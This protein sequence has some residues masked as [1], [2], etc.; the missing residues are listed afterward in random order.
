MTV[1]EIS[2]G[3]LKLK[4]SM[5]GGAVLLAA[6][7]AAAGCSTDSAPGGAPTATP[8]PTLSVLER[9]WTPADTLPEGFESLPVAEGVTDP[10]QA[11]L[12]AEAGPIRYFLAPATGG[13]LC[14][15][16]AS[17]VGGQLLSAGACTDKDRITSTGLILGEGPTPEEMTAVVVV[18]DGVTAVRTD[19][20]QSFPAENNLAFLDSAFPERVHLV[21]GAFDGTVVGADR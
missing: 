9:A 14:L 8:E 20:G 13:Q 7:F 18:P 3:T 21:G 15:V 10:A 2:G 12:A 11:R 6:G 19:Q 1:R 17:E 4:V 16:S 5:A